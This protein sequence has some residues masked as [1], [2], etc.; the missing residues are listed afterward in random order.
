M[1]GV[2]LDLPEIERGG[3]AAD[4]GVAAQRL[5]VDHALELVSGGDH[6]VAEGRGQLLEILAVVRIDPKVDAEALLGAIDEFL[7][8]GG[9]DVDRR[10]AVSVAHDRRD[11]ENAERLPAGFDADDLPAGSVRLDH[12]AA[13]R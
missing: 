1:A 9:A 6:A 13:A 12:G 5:A 2:I 4:C 3:P 10:H 7:A 11:A 8:E